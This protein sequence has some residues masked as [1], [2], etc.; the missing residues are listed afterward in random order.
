LFSVDDTKPK[1]NEMITVKNTSGRIYEIKE[2]K[3]GSE[4]QVAWANKIKSE[5]LPMAY[6]TI[7]DDHP[8]FKDIKDLTDKANDIIE[9]KWW[10]DHRAA[11]SKM[12]LKEMRGG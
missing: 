6:L 12:I 11:T 4:K 10:I 8:Q 7:S 2:C 5:K 1:E 9:A 3:V